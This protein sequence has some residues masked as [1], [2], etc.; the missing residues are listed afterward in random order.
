MYRSKVILAGLFGIG[1]PY[2]LVSLLSGNFQP[3]MWRPDQM[4]LFIGALAACLVDT[5]SPVP[6]ERL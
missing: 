4:V 1:I 5:V 6:E 3:L 2:V